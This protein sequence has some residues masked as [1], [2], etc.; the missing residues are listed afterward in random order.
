MCSGESNRIHCYECNGKVKYTLDCRCS[1][2][3]MMIKNDRLQI[4]VLKGAGALK[5]INEVVLIDGDHTC[6]VNFLYK[7]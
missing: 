6:T 3:R 7:K 1:F 5:K 4:N 2:L